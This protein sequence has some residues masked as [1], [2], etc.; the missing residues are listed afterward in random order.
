VVTAPTQE[1]TWVATGC[2]GGDRVAD[3]ALVVVFA[4]QDFA[5]NEPQDALLLVEAELV[6]TV[7][8]AAAE[9]FE[10]VSARLR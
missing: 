1:V 6:E 5:D 4:D 2:G 8:E 3:R 7:G 10:G 9:S